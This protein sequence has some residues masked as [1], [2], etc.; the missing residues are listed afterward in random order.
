[1]RLF[2]SKIKYALLLMLLVSI[3]DF[4]E[5]ILKTFAIKEYWFETFVSIGISVTEFTLIIWI[6][7]I[8]KKMIQHS[9]EKEKQYRQLIELSPEGIIVYGNGR[10]L[11]SND[12]AEKNTW[13]K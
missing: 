9:N 8:S 10:I 6:F 7:M 2:A 12:A 3:I 1:M 11:F 13:I 4:H 5:T